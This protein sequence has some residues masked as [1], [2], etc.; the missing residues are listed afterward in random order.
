[1]AGAVSFPKIDGSFGTPIY[2]EATAATTPG[3]EQALISAS[4]PVGMTRYLH[5][6]IVVCRME[7]KFKVMVGYAVV[8]SGRTG[9][10][11]SSAQ[12]VWTPPR[13]VASGSQIQVLF[14]ARDGSPG[15]D[16]E[17]FIQASDQ[18]D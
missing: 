4:V 5:Q 7:G 14:Q 6:V 18:E 8:A 12:F 2:I 16:V 13:S 15:V 3:V 11:S 17:A 1:M 10:A 9:P